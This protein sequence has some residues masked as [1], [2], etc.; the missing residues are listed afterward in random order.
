ME[1]ETERRD[2]TPEE[3]EAILPPMEPEED[4]QALMLFQRKHV[5]ANI[6]RRVKFLAAK[7]EEDPDNYQTA[8]ELYDWL[9]SYVQHQIQI[10]P[11]FG[12][13]SNEHLDSR[14]VSEQGRQQ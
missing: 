1:Q 13:K 10:D 5:R 9:G 6:L 7:L 3:I 2:P 4:L 12:E 11:K 8:N 14:D